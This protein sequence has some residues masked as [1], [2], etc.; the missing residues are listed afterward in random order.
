LLGFL[1]PFS[2]PL[3]RWDGRPAFFLLC[4]DCRN[5]C[6]EGVAFLFLSIFLLSCF[7]PPVYVSARLPSFHSFVFVEMK[8][9]HSSV[10][11]LYS[12][13]SGL[14]HSSRGSRPFGRV[15][16]LRSRPRRLKSSWKFSAVDN[17]PFPPPTILLPFPLSPNALF[18][19]VPLFASSAL[20]AR[21]RTHPLRVL[22]KKFRRT[23]FLA[24]YHVFCLLCFPFFPTGF[25]SL[26]PGPPLVSVGWW[27]SPIL[28]FSLRFS[29]STPLVFYVSRGF[30]C[31][32]ASSKNP[33]LFLPSSPTCTSVC[34]VEATF[35]GTRFPVCVSSISSWLFYFSLVFQLFARFLF[36]RFRP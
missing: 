12:L 21:S 31:V 6:P 25:P 11:P 9:S 19:S 3:L 18:F 5:V 29:L 8:S 17:V 32:F 34:F 27:F 23:R 1:F 36:P 15:H 28:D 24:P 26:P 20:A 35:V 7:S 2:V 16:S 33:P 30:F 10:F 22:A 13:L 4:R 14:G